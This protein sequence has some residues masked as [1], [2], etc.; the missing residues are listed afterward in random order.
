MKLIGKVVFV[1]K[2]DN[3]HT[4]CITLAYQ[5]RDLIYKSDKFW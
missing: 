2:L 3:Q 4:K 1:D 5:T